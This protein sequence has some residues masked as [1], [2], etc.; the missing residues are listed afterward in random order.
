MIGSLVNKTWD[1]YGRMIDSGYRIPL[2]VLSLYRIA[3][4]GYMLILNPIPDLRWISNYPDIFY[5]PAPGLPMIWR[6][7][8]PYWVLV[9]LEVGLVLAI[10][11]LLVGWR[12]PMASIAVTVIGY[13]ANST[14]FSFG[15]IDHTFMLW[16]V[17]GVLAFS[18]WGR[19]YS[20]D[21]ARRVAGLGDRAGAD[22]EEGFAP[23][24][25]VA[26]IGSL[27]ALSFL[28]A[29]LPKILR[30]WL[31]LETSAVKR[32]FLQLSFQLERDQLLAGWF[33]DFDF[34]PFWE[35]LD[36]AGVGLE[37]ALA[38]A[39]LWPFGQRWLLFA[40]WIFHL[41]NLL[42]LNISFYGPLPVYPLFFLPLV[43]PQLG[44]RVGRFVMDNR[45]AADRSGGGGPG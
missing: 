16:I 31:S 19:H 2:T 3:L 43:S 35:S 26:I 28:S 44:S 21:A 12:T 13:T 18:G 14:Y 24:W 7:F 45:P 11:A 29:A 17:P 10:C 15:K 23:G 40:A 27:L 34:Q 32:H 33:L 25:P 4:A 41:A 30:G 42:L 36:W 1:R 39:L 6:G 9:F 20:I 37:L 22:D 5:D 38:V 8:P